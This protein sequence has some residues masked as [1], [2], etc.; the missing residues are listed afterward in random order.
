ME[1]IMKYDALASKDS[2]EKVIGVVKSRGINPEFVNTKEEALQ[3]LKKLIP[4]G[5]EVMT[6]SSRTLEEIGFVDLL[7]SREHPWKNWKDLILAEKD[8]AKQMEL[9]KKSV[10]SEYFLGSVHAIAETGEAVIASNTGSQL[11]SYVYTSKNVIWV[12]GTQKIVPTLEDAIKRVREYVFPLED[13]RMKSL[14]YPG[15]NISK[16]LIFQKET[17]PGRKITLLLVNE[18]LGF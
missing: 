11:P 7:K 8:E 5:A 14:G 2:V 15:S 17:N 9:R 16:L 3:R 13:K 12:V 10:S 4:S 6:G 18:K 1:V